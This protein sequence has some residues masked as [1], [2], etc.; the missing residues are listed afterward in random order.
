LLRSDGRRVN[1]YAIGACGILL[2]VALQ[3]GLRWAPP[4]QPVGDQAILEIYTLH[5]AHGTLTVGPYSRFGWNH[6]GPMYF[7]LLAPGY[8][9][10]GH[11]E[12]SLLI[13]VLTLNLLSIATIVFVARRHGGPSLAYALMACLAMLYFRVS[14][15]PGWD[16]G[17]L[18]SNSWN[19]LS[20][21]LPFALALLLSAALGEGQLR[22]L[23]AL[24]LVASFVVQTHVAFLP[25]TAVVVLSAV[26][27]YALLHVPAR[28][29]VQPVARG[30]AWVRVLD[31]LLAICGGL[32]AWVLLFGGFDLSVA[33]H[34]VTVHALNR[35]C[36]YAIVLVVVRHAISRRHPR[37][38][39]IAHRLVQRAADGS[40]RG[41]RWVTARP[42]PAKTREIL[43]GTAAVLALLWLPPAIEQATH[44]PGNVV[45]M[46]QSL[47]EAS[48]VNAQ[49]GLAAFSSELVGV[50]R[51]SLRVAADGEIFTS[52][53]LSIPVAVLAMI[54]L[55][56]V[57]LGA[58]WASRS[59]RRFLAVL[60]GVCLV[61]SATA[62]WGMVRARGELFDHL[63]FWIVMIGIVSLSTIASALAIW[64]GA[65]F[66]LAWPWAARH[67]GIVAALLVAAFAV[68]GAYHIAARHQQTT[69]PAERAAARDLY[70][71]ID[72]DL[73]AH[74][75]ST[76]PLRVDIAQDAWLVSAGVVL[77]LYKAGRPL[78]M[79][80]RWARLFAFPVD[81]PAA[82]PPAA[83]IVL[84][85]AADAMRLDNDRGFRLVA[86]RGG[87]SAYLARTER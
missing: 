18:L 11:R 64:I 20:P 86:S 37:V 87:V 30:L 15:T 65:R 84:A 35:L 38:M 43:V 27:M 14:R 44:W 47:T 83:R 17:D 16:F 82:N 58:M 2:F 70:V 23:P 71:A 76:S 74:G 31:G 4:T 7:Y 12:E 79:D 29:V 19:P 56:L 42:L 52:A 13:T 41:V 78:V 25:V 6:P 50:L 51:P 55:V 59:G 49:A 1:R 57:A 45:R 68:E 53:S 73:R 21:M 26:A 60:A 80:E 62:F 5:A 9:L 46:A 22:V 24:A 77:D 61:A 85:D 3:V 8:V 54:Q 10:S 63:A 36:A 81:D 75:L 67:V 66:R 28:V 39:R 32:I 34:L 48:G 40:G 72:A 69:F 33:G